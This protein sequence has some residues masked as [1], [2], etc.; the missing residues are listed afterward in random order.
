MLTWVDIETTGLDPNAGHILEL[1][2]IITDDRLNEIDRRSWLI[3]PVSGPHPDKWLMDEFTTDMHGRSGLIDQVCGL[4]EPM[5][6]VE[7][8]AASWI[9]ST[10]WR[11]GE[12][13]M[14]GNSIHFDR[15]W[16]KRRM[17]KLDSVF[18]YR[19]VDVSSIKELVKR[20]VPDREFKV[21]GD[22]PHRAIADVEHS[23]AELRHY[24][25]KI[26][27]VGLLGPLLELPPGLGERG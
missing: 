16:I 13:L 25:T 18:G 8:E 21:E 15:A 2:V 5:G 7:Y 19:M 22:K 24:A 3:M 10:H 1:G 17:P 11:A 27:G 20:W 9:A 6:A 23:I 14:C 26:M 4:G 12:A